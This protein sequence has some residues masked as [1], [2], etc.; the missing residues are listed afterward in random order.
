MQL[1]APEIFL[2]LV[3]ALLIFGPSKIPEIGRSLGQSIK[4]FRAGLE[5]SESG[6]D[7]NGPPQ[8]R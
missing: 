5:E 2:V 4:E 8:S 1:G 6:E 3:I 7:K